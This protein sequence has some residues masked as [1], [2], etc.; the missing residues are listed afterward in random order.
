LPESRSLASLLDPAWLSSIV[1]QQSVIV[2][3]HIPESDWRLFKRVHSELLE[4]YCARV[5]DELAASLKARDVTAHDRYIRAYK[6][7]KN[8]DEDMARAFDDFRRSTAVMQLAIM[9]SMGLLT[10]EDLNVFSEQTQVQVRGITS[11]GTEGG[12]ANGSQPIRSETNRRSG[13]AGSR[14]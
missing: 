10:E 11:I 4:R 7:L 2:S 5:L 9:R 3:S 13:A 1:R 6:L 14:C 8:R 12:A